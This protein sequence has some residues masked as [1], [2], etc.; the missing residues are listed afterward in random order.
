MQVLFHHLITTFVHLSL[1]F[2]WIF[3][4]VQNI[5]TKCQHNQCELN[6]SSQVERNID[7]CD[8]TNNAL[9]VPGQEY[10]IIDSNYNTIAVGRS[11]PSNN[12]VCM[13]GEYISVEHDGDLT[14]TH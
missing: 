6:N 2:S 11:Q 3:L 8:L 14:T 10:D 13:E 5:A 1:N 7:Y 12:I 4:Q 9:N